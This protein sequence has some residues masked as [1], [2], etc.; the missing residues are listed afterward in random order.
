MADDSVMIRKSLHHLFAN[1]TKLEI[2]DEAENGLEAVEKAKRLRPDLI[3][4]DLSMPIMN[5]L[6]AA[7]AICAIL[8][9]VPII[10]FTLHAKAVSPADAKDACIA[11]VVPKED[12]ITLVQHAEDLLRDASSS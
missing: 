6:D 3:I 2:C 10:L 1:H 9:R 8:P 11:R 7:K 4:L 12:A 5:G